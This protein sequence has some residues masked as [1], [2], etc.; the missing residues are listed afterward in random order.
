M[1][2]ILVGCV[3]QQVTGVL[4]WNSAAYKF[5]NSVAASKLAQKPYIRPGFEF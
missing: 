2:A 5:D 3:A 1:E 4:N